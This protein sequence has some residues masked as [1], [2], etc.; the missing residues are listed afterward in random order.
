[1]TMAAR[2]R[3]NQVALLA[4]YRERGDE[5]ARQRLIDELT[6]LARALARRYADRGEPLEDLE[7]VAMVG[8]MNAIDRFDVSRNVDIASYAVPTILGEIKH[9]FVTAVG[10]STFQA[11][12]GAERTIGQTP[13]RADYPA[14]TLALD[15]RARRR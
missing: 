3:A 6:P 11:S 10:C 14:W 4:A 7:Q 12:E 5:A 15:S 8:L 9:H 13:G 1:M 2:T